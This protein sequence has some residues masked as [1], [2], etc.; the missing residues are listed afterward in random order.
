[1]NLKKL[2]D[3]AKL[4]STLFSAVTTEAT[5]GNLQ[6]ID[7]QLFLDINGDFKNLIIKFT[8]NVYIKNKLPNGFGIKVGESLITIRNI[9]GKKL[10]NNLLFEFE[11]GF[12]PTYC[13]AR[14]YKGK[15]IICNVFDKNKTD[16]IQE[17]NTKFEESTLIIQEPVDNFFDLDS[18]GQSAK[19][20]IDDDSIKG[21]YTET[22]INGYT[23]YYNYH[24]TEKVYMTGKSITNNSKP[25]NKVLKSSMV[26]KEKLNKVYSKLNVLNVKK[27]EL[28]QAKKA[29]T[30]QQK[31]IKKE[32]IKKVKGGK[33]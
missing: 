31:T 21:L 2:G 28:T 26:Q 19:N 32:K 20:K 17:S 6:S 14:N 24:P 23:G 18:R 10:N 1:M 25:I 4:K 12:S 22:P 8:G 11:G 27:T 30:K 16:A 5:K 13:E 9:L 3:I 29:Q 7:N 33:Y 15:R